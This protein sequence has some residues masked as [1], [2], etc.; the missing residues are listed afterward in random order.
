MKKSV[1]IAIMAICGVFFLACAGYVISVK[2]PYWQG[3][4]VYNSSSQQYTAQNSEAAAPAASASSGTAIQ[5]EKNETA[6][7]SGAAATAD[8]GGRPVFPPIRVDFAALKRVNDDVVGWIYCED[9][10]IDYP[11]LQGETNDSYLH[12]LYTGET[13]PSGSIFVDATNLPEFQDNNTIIYGHHMADGAMFGTLGQW[14]KQEYFDAHPCMWLL[15]PEQDYRIDLFSTY[16]VSASHDTYTIYRGSGPQFTAY[17]KRAAA[18]SAVKSNVELDPEG[19]YVMLS[20][21]AYSVYD[22]ARWVLHGL[23]VPVDSAGGV[24]R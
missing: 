7:A 5:S 12:T 19:H 18:D 17:L 15:T 20:T 24:A 8:S 22:D 1:R 11:V 10:Q 4:H 14:Q 16:I 6:A 2:L 3:R 13:H 23:L 21:C 9:T